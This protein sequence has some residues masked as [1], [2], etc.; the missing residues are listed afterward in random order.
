MINIKTNE[1]EYQIKEYYELTL[2]EFNKVNEILNKENISSYEKY[3]NMYEFLGLNELLDVI[4]VDQFTQLTKEYLNVERTSELKKSFIIDGF[5]YRLCEDNEDFFIKTP[6]FIAIESIVKRQMKFDPIYAIAILYKRTDLTKTEH[7]DS[8][9]INHKYQLF[10]DKIIVKDVI[11]IIG[12]LSNVL[13]KQLSIIK[14]E[15]I[16]SING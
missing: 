6:D 2:N 13:N 1:K 16:E 3:Y 8:A 4:T 11:Q 9:H 5:E 10:K 14:N 12:I 7:K 15:N